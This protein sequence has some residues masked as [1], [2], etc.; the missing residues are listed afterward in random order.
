M[1]EEDLF[2]LEKLL[3]DWEAGELSEAGGKRLNQLLSESQ[4]AR[5]KYAQ[6][7]AVHAALKL[8][9]ETQGVLE[10][11][12]AELPPAGFAEKAA[13]SES[14][15][16]TIWA[17]AAT[18]L[19]LLTAGWLFRLQFQ[20]AL[21]PRLANQEPGTNKLVTRSDADNASSKEEQTSEGVA[22]LTKVVDVEWPEHQTPLREGSAIKAGPLSLK[23]GLVQIEFFCGA[24][25]VIEGPAELDIESATF[26]KVQNGKLR[27]NVPVVARGFTLEVD[28]I[29][30]VDLGTEFGLSVRDGR[31]D[32]QV[33]D[34][35]VEIHSLTD[36]KQTL[37]AGNAISRAKD[38]TIRSMQVDSDLFVT[39]KELES[40]EQSQTN[41]RDLRW[42]TWSK[43]IRKD[44]QVI[45]Y[46]SFDQVGGWNRKLA[47]ATNSLFEQTGAIVGAKKVAGR[48][49]S[50]H[51]LE[52]KNPGDRVRMKIPGEFGSL[53]F[54]AWV[55]IDSLDRMF[56]SLFLTDNYNQGEP[57]WQIL[58]TGQLFF[59]VR[60][61]PDNWVRGKSPDGPAHH[62]VI[63]KPFWK[64]S[65]SGKWLHL[66][67]TFDVETSAVSHY[68]NGELI[69]S[70]KIPSAL[71]VQQTRIGE[72]TMG[73]WSIP[74]R[75]DAKFAIRNLNGTIDELLI[76]NKA[77]S[78][79]EVTE[80][81][82]NGKP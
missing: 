12:E 26:A 49:A 6:W 61:R 62:P 59:S 70:E 8:H 13:S 2:E 30:V 40:K 73:N 37:E 25:V 10:Y 33:F 76:L 44:P 60:W 66:V 67:T 57:H 11:E 78:R 81:Y 68:L 72:A 64:P 24:T 3:I 56:N 47:C 52:F 79:A 46:Y 14:R 50:K 75:P 63:S 42:Q 7:Q 19:F 35:E 18:I 9:A 41:E 51:G 4:I 48:W 45:A 80:V 20:D 22:I 74:T 23:S 15:W 34:G 54:S 21:N 39:M 77:L 43:R 1:S 55:K 36:E 65:M 16:S 17:T 32:V 28:G 53:T 71:M 27:A 82:Q 31:T 29:K 5:Q 69:H 38:G 58:D